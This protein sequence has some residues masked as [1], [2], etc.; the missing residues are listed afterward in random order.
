MDILI[1]IGFVICAAVLAAAILNLIRIGANVIFNYLEKR[2]NGLGATLI[3]IFWIIAFPIMVLLSLFFG[4][5][6][7]ITVMKIRYW[8]KS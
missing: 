5:H 3:I 6:R 4:L 1:K 2:W 8:A 7:F